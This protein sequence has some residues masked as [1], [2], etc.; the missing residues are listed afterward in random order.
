MLPLQRPVQACARRRSSVCFGTFWPQKNNVP[1]R[2]RTRKK[3]LMFW[4][5]LAKNLV[6]S[7]VPI[8]M[9]GF[10]NT[11]LYLWSFDLAQF[12]NQLFD[13]NFL[14]YFT[15]TWSCYDMLSFNLGR[16]QNS[17]VVV[18]KK[19]NTIGNWDF[20]PCRWCRL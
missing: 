19:Y 15:H 14:K 17:N 7:L 12:L 5:Y 6:N 10:D 16:S 9:D 1:S 2:V 20:M 4:G 3:L 11:W 18:K 13:I 8:Q